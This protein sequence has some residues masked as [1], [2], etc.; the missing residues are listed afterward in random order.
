[1]NNAKNS[2]L[3]GGAGI[4]GHLNHSSFDFEVSASMLSV[5]AFGA[6]IS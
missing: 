2:E 3:I 4:S 6:F 1:M 5:N